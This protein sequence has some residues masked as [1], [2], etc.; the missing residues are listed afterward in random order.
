[1]VDS[2]YCV[3]QYTYCM[4]HCRYTVDTVVLKY[5]VGQEH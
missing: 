4:I 3:C 1:M 2:R 5:I